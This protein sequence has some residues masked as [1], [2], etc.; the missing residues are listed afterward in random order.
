MRI[1][2][3]LRCKYCPEIQGTAG[4]EQFGPSLSCAFLQKHGRHSL[5]FVA[6]SLVHQICAFSEA[7]WAIYS[8]Q[9]VEHQLP[10][11]LFAFHAFLRTAQL[12][13]SSSAQVSAAEFGHSGI[14][15]LICW[16][17]KRV[18]LFNRVT[19]LVDAVVLCTA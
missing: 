6:T 1:F 10:R 18:G 7:L 17:V 3:G 19:V 15:T 11:L 4:R 5:C 12:C 8:I 13:Y 14:L 9:H 16:H 2:H